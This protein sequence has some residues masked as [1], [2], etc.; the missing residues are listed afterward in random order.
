MRVGA[1]LALAAALTLCGCSTHTTRQVDRRPDG[2]EIT[3]RA[4]SLAFMAGKSAVRD[5]KISQTEKTQGMSLGGLDQE[6]D[7]TPLTQAI[8]AIVV[9]GLAAYFTGGAS[10]LR[11]GG[12]GPTALPM[13]LG[14]WTV[15]KGM[16]A[17]Q[18][19]GSVV[20]VPADDPSTPVPEIVVPSPTP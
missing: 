8:G 6:S 15:P 9:Q 12:Q 14:E 4:R 18:R 5:V 11:T 20:L 3:T 16:K 10:T 2:T 7:A 1:V 17:V 19:G 13:S